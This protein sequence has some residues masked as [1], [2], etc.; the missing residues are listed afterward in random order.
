MLIRELLF[1]DSQEN[2]DINIIADFVVD[3]IESYAKIIFKSP[4]AAKMFTLNSMC[5][6][7]HIR[8]PLIASPSLKSLTDDYLVFMFKD[9]KSGA[10]FMYR[11]NAPYSKDQELI[12]TIN[13]GFLADKIRFKPILAHEIQHAADYAKSQRRAFPSHNVSPDAM[14]MDAYMRHPA[15]INARFAEALLLMSKSNILN[16]SNL[17]RFINFLFNKKCDI[18]VDL[19]PKEQ[20]AEAQKIIQRL[21]ARAYKFYD[22]V[23]E[24]KTKTP[25]AERVAKIKKLISKTVNSR[26]SVI[27][28]DSTD[29]HDINAL[30]T[31]TAIN[32]PSFVKKFPNC[33][34]FDLIIFSRCVGQPIPEIKNPQIGKLLTNRIIIFLSDTV[35]LASF[36]SF[37][38][39]YD[40]EYIGCIKINLANV[41][42]PHDLAA[43]LTHE[44]RHAVDF[45]SSK[46]KAMQ[47]AQSI[48]SDIIGRANYLKHP[49]EVNARLAEVMFYMTQLDIPRAKLPK[50]IDQLFKGH[51][52]LPE[53]IGKDSTDPKAIKR[54]NHLKSRVYKY[55]D[56]VLSLPK[57]DKTD[58]VAKK[59]WITKVNELIKKY[60][61]G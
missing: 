11:T 23:L 54:I 53:I 30:S 37:K 45:E 46:G 16:R 17:N 10:A 34:K 56:E 42:S 31:Y 57:I 21:K 8:M 51:L 35:K 47:G 24:I 40:H 49:F 13:P 4:N 41:T 29:T 60:I 61:N 36:N 9:M 26:Q 12:I 20:A 59:T 6:V 39:T 50:Y 38:P 2:K 33:K 22:E 19:W 14:G 43:S 52:L 48:S 5:R 28:E 15:E 58:P 1:E 32:L 18:T 44:M 27:N 3:N 7:L 55:Y 25:S